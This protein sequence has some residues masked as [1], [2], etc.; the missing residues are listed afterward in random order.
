MGKIPKGL[1]DKDMFR[2]YAEEETIESKFLQAEAAEDK[3]RRQHVQAAPKT[4]LSIAYL[5]PELVEK[6]GRELLALKMALYQEG[7][8]SYS[9]KVKREGHNIVLSPQENKKKG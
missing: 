4:N 6:L 3:R 2:D 5:T 9:M 8:T 1:A 7:I